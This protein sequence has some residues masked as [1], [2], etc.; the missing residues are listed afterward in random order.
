MGKHGRTWE[1]EDVGIVVAAGGSATRFGGERNKLLC[2]LNGL[3]V[4]CHC[5]K[6]FLAGGV[7]AESIVVVVPEAQSSDFRA[8]FEEHSLPA[9]RLINGGVARQD[10][11]WAGINA[12]PA[13]VGIVAIHDAARPFTTLELLAA[14][15]ESARE[16]GS[17]VAAHK[18]TDTVKIAKADGQVMST[19]D[20]E[21]LWAAETPQVFR[22]SLIESAYGRLALSGARLTDD[23]QAVEQMGGD[24]FLVAHESEN[25]KITFAR[26]LE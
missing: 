16:R 10:S 8:V 7:P 18:V 3:P 9:V 22:R 11:V 12:L 5:L 13:C 25:R 19:P 6:T 1:F 20:R 23:A 2:E 24:V 4:V 26:D 15:V 21:I 14:C 17:G